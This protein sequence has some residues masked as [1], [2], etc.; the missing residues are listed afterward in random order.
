MAR[1]AALL[2]TEINECSGHH[3][4]PADKQKDNSGPWM[5]SDKSLIVEHNPVNEFQ[6]NP[7][8]ASP[9]SSHSRQQAN[10]PFSPDY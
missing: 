9:S 1:Q 10:I 7:R 2:S 6:E 8:S 4:H 5:F 3:P